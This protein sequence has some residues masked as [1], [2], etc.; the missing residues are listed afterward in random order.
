MYPTKI[1]IKN[2]KLN[3]T[4]DDESSD[5]ISLKYLRDECPC[6]GCKGETILL[7]TIRPP[8]LLSTDPQM[9]KI[10]NIE[11]IGN[12]AIKVIWKD[13]HKTGVYNW[14]YLKDLSRGEANN[15][16]FNYDPLI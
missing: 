3:I 7:K 12:Y 14:S 2:D 6:A 15:E 16:S 11:M 9:Y 8:K 5:S 1:N 4:W 10:E 13:G